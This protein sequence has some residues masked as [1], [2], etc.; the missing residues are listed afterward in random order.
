MQ[1][2]DGWMDNHQTLIHGMRSTGVGNV[3]AGSGTLFGGQAKFPTFT[4]QQR[5]RGSAPM[6]SMVAGQ[7]GSIMPSPGTA[8]KGIE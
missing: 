6:T 5:Y 3:A 4:Q 2:F 1:D 7:T 8:T